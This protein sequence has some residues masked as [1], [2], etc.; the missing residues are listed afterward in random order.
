M[1]Q[2]RDKFLEP[3]FSIHLS[4]TLV[5]EKNSF[6]QLFIE[7]FVETVYTGLCTM[8]ISSGREGAEKKKR[9]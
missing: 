6:F 7:S 4:H 2:R 9:E 5:L 1:C 3:F 8:K